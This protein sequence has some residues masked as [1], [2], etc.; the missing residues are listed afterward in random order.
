MMPWRV[1]P[2]VV[3]AAGSGGTTP[4]VLVNRIAVEDLVEQPLE[5]AVVNDREDAEGSVIQLVNSDEAREV[6]QCP[7]EMLGIDPPRP[8]PPASTQFWI[9]A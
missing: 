8:F 1:K 9:V 3:S 4:P 2:R 7:V 5:G 6:G